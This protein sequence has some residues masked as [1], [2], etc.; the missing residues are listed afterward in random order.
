MVL[1]SRL[2]QDPKVKAMKI[3]R[4]G[5][6]QR[7]DVLTRRGEGVSPIP[8]ASLGP[9]KVTH[10]AWTQWRP[11]IPWKWCESGLARLGARRHPAGHR[12]LPAR[13][14]VVSGKASTVAGNFSG[15][16]GDL[17]GTRVETFSRSGRRSSRERPRKP[18]PGWEKSPGAPRVLAP[19]RSWTGPP[20]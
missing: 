10:A 20:C 6:G 14:G 7:A 4:G 1:S 18:F 12:P 16:T 15:T 3:L 2:E 17:L 9:V 5:G 11:R 13:A 8:T 19:G